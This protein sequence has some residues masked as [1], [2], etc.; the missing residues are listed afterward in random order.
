MS[1]ALD[2]PIE[3]FADNPIVIGFP[4]KASLSFGVGTQATFV[5][6]DLLLYD[7]FFAIA[8]NAKSSISI[9]PTVT[10]YSNGLA[11]F[12]F[13]AIQT[14]AMAPAGRWTGHCFLQLIAGG[15][16]EYFIEISPY[17]VNPVPMP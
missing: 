7:I 6:A 13:S 14:S 5:G 3:N 1:C 8:P 2:V 9:A 16:P 12:E 10:K 17:V 4:W 11:E 15:S